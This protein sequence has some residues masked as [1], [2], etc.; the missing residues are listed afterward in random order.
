M[1][2]L[3][4]ALLLVV[5]SLPAAADDGFAIA[6]YKQLRGGAGNVVVSPFN[7]SEALAMVRAGARGATARELPLHRARLNPR[8]AVGAAA[9]WSSGALRTEYVATVKKDF[10]A[11]AESLS[12]ANPAAAAARINS[13]ASQSTRGRIRSLI[14]PAQLT[15]RTAA[16]LTA[17]IYMKAQWASPFNRLG[18]GNH[19]FHLRGADV[20]VP[21][22]HSTRYTRFARLGAV[23]IL[24]L[25]YEAKDLSMLIVMPDARNGLDALE[26]SL[27]PQLLARWTGALREVEVDI[28]LPRFRGA[29]SANLVEPLQRLGISTLFDPKRA[30]LSGMSA[31]PLF[32]SD[33]LHEAFIDVDE[34]GTVAAAVS[35]EEGEW[36]STEAPPPPQPFNA[37]HPFLYIIRSENQILFIGRVVDPRG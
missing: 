3:L 26:K 1:R 6:L 17:A 28:R 2:T 34:A 22:M 8:H 30:D 25:Q 20:S 5:L 18:T 23:R 7:V 35:A 9:V 19:V 11:T 10:G 13:W 12:F 15:N 21:T 37:D 24:E 33:V 36:T 32:I 31:K 27:T 14:A 29:T 16:V 4:V